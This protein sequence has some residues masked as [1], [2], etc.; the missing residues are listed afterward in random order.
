[1]ELNNIICPICKE[2]MILDIIDYKIQT[3]CKN[4]HNKILLIKD[5]NNE[6]FKSDDKNITCKK[7]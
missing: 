3:K 7:T 2:Q 5:Y 6:I 4:N 1:M